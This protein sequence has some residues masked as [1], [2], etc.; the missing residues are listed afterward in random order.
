M[1]L[2]MSLLRFQLHDVT[3]CSMFGKYTRRFCVSIKSACMGERGGGAGYLFIG[4][5]QPTC[6]I[7]K[8]MTLS[9]IHIY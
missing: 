7:Y 6:F 5:N 1:G 9:L 8:D 2:G 3:W 4:K